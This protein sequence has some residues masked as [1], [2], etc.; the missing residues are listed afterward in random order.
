KREKRGPYLDRKD[1]EYRKKIADTSCDILKLQPRDWRELKMVKLDSQPYPVPEHW[2]STPEGK[3]AHSIR[4]AAP[5]DTPKAV[6]TA[7]MTGDEYFQTLCREEAGDFVRRR[8]S[9]VRGLRQDRPWIPLPHGYR[10]VIFWA[11][12]KGGLHDAQDYLV[13]PPAGGYRFLEVRLS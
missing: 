9:A 8:V 13:Q 10:D 7:G 6:Y 2:L 5:N 12:E 1:P 4:L 11:M 3:F